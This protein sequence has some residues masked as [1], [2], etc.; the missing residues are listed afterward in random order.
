MDLDVVWRCGATMQTRDGTV[1]VADLWHP[2]GPGPWPTLLVR[3][4]YG[5]GVASAITAPH[6]SVLAREGYL[7]VT[8]DVRGRGDSGGEFDPFVHEADDGFD[9]VAWAA[10]LPESDGSVGMYGFSYQGAVQLLAAATGPPALRA[11]APAMCSA[12]PADGFLWTNGALRLGFAV[13]WAAQLSGAEGFVG[14]AGTA[15][16]QRR[17]AT[18]R[19]EE[20][21]RWDE[22]TRGDC[23]PSVDPLALTL[24]ALFTIGW[25][26][27]FAAA[28][29]R[30]LAAYAGP[31]WLVAAPWSHMPWTPDPGVATDAHLAFFDEHVA[32]RSPRGLLPRVRSLPSGAA[33]WR[34]FDAWPSVEPV[35]L[36]FASA[37]RAATR[38]GDGALVHGA[39]YGPPVLAV[40]QPMVPVPSVGGAYDDTLGS[41]G[42]VDQRAV[43]DRTDV[44]CYTT[45][46]LPD[47]IEL[48][49]SAR[50]SA[51]LSSDAPTNDAC[52]TLCHVEPDGH[53]ANLAFGACRGAGR[54][55]FDLSPVHALIPAGHQ[56]RVAVAPSAYPEIDV[57]VSAGPAAQVTRALG[58][59]SWIDLPLCVR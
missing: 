3:T 15:V 59:G 47:A 39:G 4:A 23:G 19:V 33:A 56:L 38:F 10:S 44:L 11:I 28:G 53:V 18:G 1:L 16:M 5:R 58:S 7:V 50:V 43:Q 6:P 31:S 26:D 41:V 9:A 14:D 42:R 45:D 36:G 34:C 51:E 22:W 30:D 27:T 49:G 8:Q 55:T 52:V 46:P 48:F 20:W 25:Y 37:G 54:L 2:R 29:W 40:H 24:P 57:N 35:R 13:S 17:C 12:D 21:H 32:R